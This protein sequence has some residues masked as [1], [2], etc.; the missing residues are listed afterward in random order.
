[1]CVCVGRFL[2]LCAADLS[3]QFYVTAA[4]VQAKRSR[5]AACAPRLAELNDLVKVRHVS[6]P[7]TRELVAQFAVVVLSCS[8][9]NFDLPHALQVNAW[10][11]AASQRVLA[12]RLH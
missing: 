3:S 6:G 10:C 2:P 11:V 12:L 1:M 7:L 5:A 8:A 9:G 4:D